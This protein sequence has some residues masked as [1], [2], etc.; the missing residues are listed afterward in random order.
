MSF[1]GT[2][3]LK[4]VLGTFIEINFRWYHSFWYIYCQ[5]PPTKGLQVRVALGHSWKAPKRARVVNE[6][7]CIKTHYSVCFSRMNLYV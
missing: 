1:G 3:N 6:V 5:V 4:H 7:S 2:D